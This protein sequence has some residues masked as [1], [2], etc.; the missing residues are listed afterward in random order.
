VFYRVLFTVISCGGGGG[1]KRWPPPRS[2]PGRK[3]TIEQRKRDK[4]Y[5]DF[6]ERNPD[7]F[8]G[9]PNEYWSP[10]RIK[11]HIKEGMELDKFRPTWDRR[12]TDAG[13]AILPEVKDA[14]VAAGFTV[15][16]IAALTGGGPDDEEVA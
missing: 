7:K 1:S 5:E 16:E 4:M 11:D 14:L 6:R 8:P 9:D 3:D 2:Y 13:G 12:W 15:E 10:D